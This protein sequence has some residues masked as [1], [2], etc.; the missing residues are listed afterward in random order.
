MIPT[1][2]EAA[3]SCLANGAGELVR[4]YT[5]S[6]LLLNSCDV[7]AKGYAARTDNF[8]LSTT[9]NISGELRLPLEIE[10]VFHRH[11]LPAVYADRVLQ[12]VS[13]DFLIRL[14]SV[15]DAVLEDIYEAVLPLVSSNLPEAEIAKRVRLAWQQDDNGHVK[16]LNYL[17][18]EAGLLSPKGRR[19]TLQMVFDRYYEMREVRHSLV[20]NAGVLSPKHLARLKLL[21]GRLPED[22][23]HGSLASAKFLES[24]AVRLTVPDILSLRHWAYL[25][26]IGYLQTAFTESSDTYNSPAEF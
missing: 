20:H 8:Q 11:Q 18:V 7:A 16:L 6:A 24:G 26:V 19:S 9:S 10:V 25:T 14:V 3:K 4:M 13:E 17:V 2:V 21:A 23:R 5:D 15:I 12:R 1:A 22:I